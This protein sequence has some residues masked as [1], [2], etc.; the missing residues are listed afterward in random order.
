MQSSAECTSVQKPQ[1]TAK[2]APGPF[3]NLE[4]KSE[5]K[6]S[7][8][9]PVGTHDKVTVHFDG[10][11]TRPAVLD[12]SKPAVY[13]VEQGDETKKH[14]MGET[15]HGTPQ[16]TDPQNKIEPPAQPSA[17]SCAPLNPSAGTMCCSSSGENVL[18]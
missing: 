14:Y 17:L 6:A 16:L 8:L 3:I 4:G 12:P 2:P 13:I 7:E 1:E 15:Q 9:P 11:L 10:K 18:L 5:I